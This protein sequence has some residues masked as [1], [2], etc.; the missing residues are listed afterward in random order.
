VVRW[1]GDVVGYDHRCGGLLTAGG[2]SATL[3]ALKTARDHRT[4]WDVRNEGTR[5]GAPLTCYASTEAHVVVDRAADIIGIG[6]HQVRHVP[7]E[8]NGRMDVRAL[9]EAIAADRRAGLLPFAVV[10]T[11][12]TTAIGAIDPLDAIA[13]VCEAEG[14]WFHID[15]AYGAPATLVPELRPLFAGIER[16]DSIALDPHKWLYVPL[17]VGCVLVRDA[18]ALPES[19]GV[20]ASYVHQD[21]ELVDRGDD[22]AF[23]GIDFSRGFSALKVWISLLAYGRDAYERRIRHDCELARYLHDRVRARTDLEPMGPVTL[24]IACFRYVPP[25]VDG[26][27]PDAQA[28]LDRLNERIMTAIQTDGRAFCSNAEVAGR[29]ALR[30]CIVNFRTEAPDVDMLLDVAT[31]VGA[32]IHADR[33]ARGDQNRSDEAGGAP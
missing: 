5:A 23:W 19:F 18:A 25:D 12:G 26:A 2:A 8:P 31:E 28:Y 27:D 4:G 20:E 29:Y 30:A 22:A 15:G 9:R 7:V 6:A 21:R 3:V 11:A 1:F 16:A 33:S 24:S 32:A 13:E 10:G 14:L 17:G